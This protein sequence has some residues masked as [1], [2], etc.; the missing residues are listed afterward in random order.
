M[1]GG[2]RTGSGQK[3]LASR[4]LKKRRQIKPYVD[5]VTVE[6]ILEEFGTLKNWGHFLD[7]QY[8]E[9]RADFLRLTKEK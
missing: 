6:R 8:A 2:H 5:A 9:I 1:R 4:G 7:A 3:T